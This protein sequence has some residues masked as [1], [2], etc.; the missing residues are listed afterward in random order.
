MM[1]ANGLTY[2]PPHS[3]G[4]YMASKL[5]GFWALAPERELPAPIA[6]STR[7]VKGPAFG[8]VTPVAAGKTDWSQFRGG[9]VRG[10]STDTAISSEPK[11]SWKVS[12]GG[13]LTQPVVA[14]GKL[15]TADVDCGTVYAI[16]P[17]DGSKI[18]DVT[19]S[20][21][22]DSPP[23]IYGGMAIFG[24]ADGWVYAVRLADGALVWKF[25]AAPADVKTVAL[26]QVES[27]WPVHGSVL[28]LDGVAYVSS[29]RST[30]LDGGISLYGL[31]P[32]TGAIRY[33]T[34]YESTHPDYKKL[35]DI[36]PAVQQQEQS[37]T[38]QNMTDYK[39]PGESDLS[40]AFSMEGGTIRDILVSDGQNV[41]LHTAQF[42]AE[43]NRKDKPTR[44]IFSTSGLLDGTENHRSHFVLGTGDFSDVPV[45]YSWII[46]GSGSRK[47]IAMV[48]PTGLMMVFDDDTL[49]GVKR[50]GGKYTL[51]KTG[52]SP[53]T[54]NE[55]PGPDFVPGGSVPKMEYRQS[56]GCRPRAMI[57]AGGNLYFG[58]V[59]NGML[60]TTDSSS[61][62]LV[63][64]SAETGEQVADYPLDSAVRWDGMSA[65]GGNLF[66]VTENGELQCWK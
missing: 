62:Q 53:L 25:F 5:W 24:S 39:T 54:G 34:N 66:L 40:D 51:Y 17:T 30:W 42:D 26:D 37:R 19:V 3:C 36:D 63:V 2:A 6:D 31:D 48:A 55:K 9:P 35:A 56:L 8:N 14:A 45:A 10:G 4:C 46:N 22:V 12:L 59:P 52:I 28:I 29:G 11:P 60:D 27:L 57:Q 50:G 58:G 49:W 16:D 44:H 64:V 38:D 20:G 41:F 65:G 47:N 33:K 61:G 18:W 13:R 15:L 43:L 32:A 23:A 7:L 21:R 1:P